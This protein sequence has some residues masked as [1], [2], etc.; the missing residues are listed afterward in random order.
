M[1]I[2]PF[3]D[4]RDEDDLGREA[5]PQR[6]RASP[7]DDGAVLAFSA[8][9]IRLRAVNKAMIV[10]GMRDEA[11][12]NAAIRLGPLFATTNRFGNAE[13]DISGLPDGVHDLEIDGEVTSTDAVG[14]DLEIPDGADYIWAPFRA[15]VEKVGL[16]VTP[17]DGT[18]DLDLVSGALRAALRPMWIASGAITEGGMVR[19]EHVIIHH[20]A[21]FNARSDLNALAY[22]GG[23][24][25]HYLVPPTGE[26]IKLVREVDR[27]WHA[28]YSHWQ[29]REA[30]NKLSIGIEITHH[31]GPFNPEQIDAVEELVGRIV[32]ASPDLMPQN[33]IAHSDIA[34]NRPAARPPKTLNRKSG[35]PS[36][37]F[38]WERLEARQWGLVPEARALPDAFLG[39]YFVHRPDG[40]LVRGDRDSAQVYGG[41]VVDEV[42]DAVAGLQEHLALIGYYVGAVD[43][44]FGSVTGWAVRLFQQHIFSGI[45]Q[46]GDDPENSGDGRCDRATAE[47]LIAVRAAPGLGM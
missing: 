12:A 15:K 1:D 2:T 46:T 24:S 4:G 35:D 36:S 5:R 19:V 32:A 11:V 16:D 23:V 3:G 30:L 18:A 28:G 39:G 43:G 13:I 40:A 42:E 45:R 8:G 25:A 31:D 29:G 44:Q 22:G 37:R 26:T 21:G 7:D 34:L 17:V 38:P 10:D 41:E 6:D 20:T 47:M 14:P 9:T 33:I 27:A